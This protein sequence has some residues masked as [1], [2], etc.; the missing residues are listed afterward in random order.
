[1]VMSLSTVSSSTLGSV[2]RQR[3][4][5]RWVSG[6]GQFV[7]S[8]RSID[9]YMGVGQM[10]VCSRDTYTYRWHLP[11]VAISVELVHVQRYAGFSQS[12]S[13]S[14]HGSDDGSMG[15]GG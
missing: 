12:S 8:R 15:D 6:G 2:S 5:S 13:L 7:P 9:D 3:T 14:M 4:R 10:S 11:H 1:M